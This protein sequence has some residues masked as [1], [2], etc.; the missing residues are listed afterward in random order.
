MD[1]FSSETYFIIKGHFRDNAQVVVILVECALICNIHSP[2]YV[3]GEVSFFQR[4]SV[5]PSVRQ[6]DMI[7]VSEVQIPSNMYTALNLCFFCN[8]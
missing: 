4:L 8:L 5:C 3:S 2:P 7:P 1:T 6:P